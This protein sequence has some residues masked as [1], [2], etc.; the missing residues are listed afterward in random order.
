MMIVDDEIIYTGSSNM[1]DQ[2]FFYSSEL[3]LNI[4]DS[5]LAKQTRSKLTREHLGENYLD[6][7]DNNF[8]LLFDSFK[9]I[10]TENRNMILS[11]RPL[12]GRPVFMSPESDYQLLSKYV[13]YPN[14]VTK[15]LH[16]LGLNTEDFYEELKYKIKRM[17]TSKL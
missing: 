2:S 5:Q 15:A 13:Y 12:R 4:F 7:M 8:D 9:K 3:C 11:K 17:F 10:A 16:K 6:E 1:D 14:K